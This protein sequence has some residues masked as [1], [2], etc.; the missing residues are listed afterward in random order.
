[1][2]KPL[3][4]SEMTVV[5]NEFEIGENSPDRTLM[6]RALE[7]AFA[8]HNYG[9]M[10]IGNRS[11]IEHVPIERLAAFYQR[12]Y[13]P[14][15]A[16][17]TIAGK[18]DEAKTLALIASAFG[19]LPKPTRTLPPSYTEE[20]TQDGERL[21]TL[22]RVGDTQGIIALYHVPAGSHPDAPVLEVLAGVLG[23]TPSGRLYKA[24]ADHKKTLSAD[25]N[26]TEMHDPGFI[27]AAARLRTDQSLDDARQI[28]LKTVEGFINEPPTKE[29]VERVKTRVLK[30]IDEEMADS[31]AV[32]IDLSEYASQ[33]DWRLLFIMRDLIKKVTP[34]DVMR[35]AKAY[36][37][38]SNRTLAVFIPTKTPDRAEIPEAP[39]I[40]SVFKDFKGSAKISEGETFD[41]TP[42][43]IESRVVR[44]KLPGGMKLVL[45]PKK[46]SGGVVVATITVRFGDE[47]SVM[48]KSAVAQITGGLL[49]HGTKSKSRQQIHDEM[50]KLKTSLLVNGSPTSATANIQ[51][52]E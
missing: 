28:L 27:M 40:S 8:W 3:L 10:P 30:Q 48:G 33:G 32:A 49:M 7:T 20:P 18:F 50:D 37:K 15:N 6:Q 23:D 35:V 41:P 21:V 47:K 42:A 19:K 16:L 45:L 22:R 26:M 11:D 29:E 14:D 46:T 12:Y 24:P 52:V 25:M 39:V 44:D 36:L 5:R 38:E 17:L 31:Q 2:E 1:M 51:T 4:D 34:E 43:N 9:K 13:Q